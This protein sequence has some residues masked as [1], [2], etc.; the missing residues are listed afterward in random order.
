MSLLNIPLVMCYQTKWCCTCPVRRGLI[1]VSWTSWSSS[2][3]ELLYCQP[4]HT[5]LRGR[6]KKDKKRETGTVLDSNTYQNVTGERL[7]GILEFKVI[8]KADEWMVKAAQQV[9][10]HVKSNKIKSSPKTVSPRFFCVKCNYLASMICYLSVCPSICL[11]LSGCLP[12]SYPTVWI[13][14]KEPVTSHWQ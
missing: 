12:V 13:Q 7:S 11:S 2:I 6:F 4:E 5:R 10:M 3:I 8:F 9:N 14:W 1:S